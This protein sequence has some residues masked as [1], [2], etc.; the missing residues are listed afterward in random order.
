M[1]TPR[2]AVIGAGPGGLTLAR[3]LQQHGIAVTV[4]ER[5][6]GPDA[7]D[8]GGTLDMQC[9]TGQVALDAAGLLDEFFARS[10]PEGQDGRMLDRD[11][12]ILADMVAAPDEREKPEIDRGV[13]RRMLL[14]SLEPGT[15]EWG[16][17]LDAGPRPA[18]GGTS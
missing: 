10:R 8:Q 12:T 16:R 3:V 5:D 1:T 14:D 18:T 13:L 4:H 11:G 6:A 7:R 9:H 2:I 15:I 17:T